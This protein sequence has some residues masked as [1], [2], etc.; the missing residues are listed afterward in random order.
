MRTH[1]DVFQDFIVGQESFLHTCEVSP[2][3]L[4]ESGVFSGCL[5]LALYHLTLS[6]PSTLTL[7]RM[8]SSTSE[9]R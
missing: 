8:S 7:I 3:V 6:D 4:P 5:L 9:L 2:A 1:N